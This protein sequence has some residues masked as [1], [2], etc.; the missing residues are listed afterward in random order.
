MNRLPPLTP[1]LGAVRQL[2][3]SLGVLD[4]GRVLRAGP[5]STLLADPDGLLAELTDE[6]LDGFV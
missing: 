2:A 1:A 6:S 3:D 4:R 5:T